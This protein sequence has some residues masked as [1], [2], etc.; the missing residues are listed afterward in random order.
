MP[1]R[2]SQRRGLGRVDHVLVE[3][4]AAHV[5]VAVEEVGEL[6][7]LLLHKVQLLLLLLLH[8]LRRLDL[9]HPAAAQSLSLYEITYLNVNV[10]SFVFIFHMI[11]RV[12]HQ[13]GN[14]VGLT[15]ILGVP[16]AGGL[17]L[18]LPTA[19]A[20]WWKAPYPSHHNPTVG[21]P[22]SFC[23]YMSTVD[24]VKTTNIPGEG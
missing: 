20:G 24:V 16:L 5:V 14:K 2:G 3:A 15:Y 1:T 10:F 13:V 18:W 9:H 7:E 22:E 8:V 17:Q 12:T 23:T 19:Q 11:Y 6:A 4:V 21:A